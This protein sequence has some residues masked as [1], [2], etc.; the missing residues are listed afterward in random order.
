MARGTYIS[1]VNARSIATIFPLSQAQTG[2]KEGKPANVAAQLLLDDDPWR[3]N[4]SALG[5]SWLVAARNLRLK[6]KQYNSY[7]QTAG[8]AVRHER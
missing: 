5:P 1:Q 6:T 2:A 3:G 4:Q 7:N 8:L